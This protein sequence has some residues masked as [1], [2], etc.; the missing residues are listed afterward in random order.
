MYPTVYPL[1]WPYK[2]ALWSGLQ[3]RLQWPRVPGYNARNSTSRRWWKKRMWQIH[4]NWTDGWEMFLIHYAKTSSNL[5][6]CHLLQSQVV[7]VLMP[8]KE[9]CNY[10]STD[11]CGKLTRKIFFQNLV[12]WENHSHDISF[13]R[14]LYTMCIMSSCSSGSKCPH[15]S[16]GRR[17]RPARQDNTV[18]FI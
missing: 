15:V 3:K 16:Q 1:C 2:T 6:F 12:F 5:P 11:E 7:I 8:G 17:C 13:R 10:L 18:T 4:P 9:Q 14:R